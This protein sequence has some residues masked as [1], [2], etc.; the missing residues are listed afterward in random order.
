[1]LIVITNIVVIYIIML[2]EFNARL[3]IF[4]NPWG[5]HASR[6]L[7]DKNI[8]ANF[9]IPPTIGVFI[10]EECIACKVYL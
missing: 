1:M 9:L 8:G 3:W 2:S 6:H 10:S 7:R 5:R 4:W